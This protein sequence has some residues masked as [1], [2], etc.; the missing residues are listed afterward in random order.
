MEFA[1]ANPSP[2]VLEGA[3]L[4]GVIETEHL[5][6]AASAGL[7]EKAQT[8]GLTEAVLCCASTRS[9]KRGRCRGLWRS[10][11]GQPPCAGRPEGHRMQSGLS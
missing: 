5:E 10:A 1:Q 11:G 6:I 3:V 4:G 2:L 7:I 9:R 8:M